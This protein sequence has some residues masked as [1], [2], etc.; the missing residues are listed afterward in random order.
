[1]RSPRTSTPSARSRGRPVRPRQLGRCVLSLA[2]AA[3][4]LQG[5]CCRKPADGTRRDP[6]VVAIA[7]ERAGLSEPAIRGKTLYMQYCAVCHG[8]TGAGDGF[9]AYNLK[10]APSDLRGVVAAGNEGLVSKVMREGSVAIGKSPLCPPFG[11]SLDEEARGF[12]LLFL[13]EGLQESR[14]PVSLLKSRPRW[15]G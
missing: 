5:V 11:R 12:I 1:M 15:S 6:A 7:E 3:L 10:P 8:E 2:A 13:R 14:G 9:N 4:S